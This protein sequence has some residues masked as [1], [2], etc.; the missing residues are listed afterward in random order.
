MAEWPCC[1][2][3]LRFSPSS[4]RFVPPLIARFVPPLRRSEKEK[5]KMAFRLFSH[6][7]PLGL[8][9]EPRFPRERPSTDM[10]VATAG[11]VSR[12]RSLPPHVAKRCFRWLGR[13]TMAHTSLPSRHR[14]GGVPKRCTCRLG[15]PAMDPRVPSTP[16]HMWLSVAPVGWVG[17]GGAPDRPWGGQGAPHAAKGREGAP[18]PLRGVAGVR[19][20]RPRGCA[21][22]A[23][24]APGVDGVRP[25]RSEGW[26]GCAPSGPEGAQGAPQPPS[27]WPGRAPTA[28]RGGWGA[29]HP[30]PRVRPSRPRGGR[31][32][33]QQPPVWAGRA[34]RASLGARPGHPRGGGKKVSLFQTWLCLLLV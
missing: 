10:S 28:P 4:L 11:W 18:Q 7:D 6:K 22:C 15:V 1:H 27:G 16:P 32:A 9:P 23:P 12:Q 5:K 31:G 13:P 21:G 26:M 17:G 19:P 3:P 33:P 25:N 30:A 14:K 34:P 24:T 8:K 2:D 29:P 20:I